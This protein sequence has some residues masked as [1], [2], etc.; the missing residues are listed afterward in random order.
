M[1]LFLGFRFAEFLGLHPLSDKFRG[2]MRVCTTMK[3]VSQGNGIQDDLEEAI[4]DIFVPV[5]K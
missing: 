5:S 1:K 3:I 2:C 4:R